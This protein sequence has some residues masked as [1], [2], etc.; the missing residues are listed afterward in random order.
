MAVISLA[1]FHMTTYQASTAQGWSLFLKFISPHLGDTSFGMQCF[2]QQNL[3]TSSVNINSTCQNHGACIFHGS[4]HFLTLLTLPI[5][6]CL[7]LYKEKFCRVFVFQ[8]LTSPV[9]MEHISSLGS[10][11]HLYCYNS[12]DKGNSGGAACYLHWILLAFVCS[13]VWFISL[14]VSFGSFTTVIQAFKAFLRLQS[15]PPTPISLSPIY[16]H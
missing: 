12:M 4:W 11:L 13:E 10:N 7:I 1:S 3:P 5:N 6:L 2:Y 15:H 16:Q 9:H 14:A 8:K